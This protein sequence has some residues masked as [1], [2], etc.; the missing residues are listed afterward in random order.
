VSSEIS[1]TTLPEIIEE[2]AD[3]TAPI[4]SN[5]ESTATTTSAEIVWDT[6]EEA[7][8]KAWYSTTTP[9]VVTNE[10]LLEEDASLL[11]SHSLTLLGLTASTTY[12]YL[13][14]STDEAGNTATSTET[15][16]TTSP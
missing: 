16:F 5:L 15:S 4:I 7:T 1:F 13:V 14:S 12:H 3:V 2:P 10:T 6:D 8:S 9:L 11:Q